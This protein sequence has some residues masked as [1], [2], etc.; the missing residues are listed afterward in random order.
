VTEEVPFPPFK[1]EDAVGY[2][3]PPR[4][5]RF[6]PGR[7]GNLKGRPKGAISLAAA[8]LLELEKLVVVTEGG[9]RKKLSKGEA[10]AKQLVNRALN[11]DPKAANLVLAEARRME[12]PEEKAT[13]VECLRADD[14][15][16]MKNIIRR[17]RLAEEPATDAESPEEENEQ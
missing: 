8:L 9:K 6:Q 14:K 13:T 5:T 12:A 11:N 16:V 2:G 17:I 10:L 7:S 15:L 4:H 3:H 1:T